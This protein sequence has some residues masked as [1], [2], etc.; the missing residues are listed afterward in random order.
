MTGR[1]FSQWSLALAFALLPA[2]DQLAAEEKRL[3]WSD[4]AELAVVATGG[5]SEATTLGF[6]NN[7]AHVWANAKFSLDL[8]GLRAE[9][10]VLTRT[11]IGT[12][13]NNFIL[14]EDRDTRLSAENYFLR[15][16]YDQDITNGYYWFAGAGW[17]QN[18]FAGFDSRISAVGGAG[19]TWFDDKA[20]RLKTDAGITFTK[21]DPRVENPAADDQFLGLRLGYDY[22][23]QLTGSTAYTSVLILDENLNE[24]DDLRADFSNA[25]AVSIS[26]HLAL[27]VALQFLF[28]NQPAVVAV[29]ITLPNGNPSGFTALAELDEVDSIFTVSLLVTY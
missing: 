13:P 14:R 17:E 15:G 7:L 12:G 11:A 21:E 27:K 3:G 29:P 8:G 16:R 20:R 26:N 28:D 1:R 23:R 18:E 10:S 19:K 2:P 22:F 24:T 5:N 6:K 25:V 4:T 9:T